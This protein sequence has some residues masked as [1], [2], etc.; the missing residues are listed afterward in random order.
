MLNILIRAENLLPGDSWTEPDTYT[1][2]VY[3]TNHSAGF[4]TVDMIQMKDD[5]AVKS[6]QQRYYNEL[7]LIVNRPS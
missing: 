7:K 2:I 1:Y 6:V 3:K 5:R 4:V